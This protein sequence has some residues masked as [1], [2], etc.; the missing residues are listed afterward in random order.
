M[1][2]PGQ[3]QRDWD[4][5]KAHNC[6]ILRTVEP[7]E[8]FDEAFVDDGPAINIEFLNGICC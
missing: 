4:F 6:E 7:P 5:A 3:D 8:D 1:A 2:V